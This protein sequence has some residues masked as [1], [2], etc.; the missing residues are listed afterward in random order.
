MISNRLGYALLA[1]LLVEC[2]FGEQRNRF[3]GGVSSGAIVVLLLFLKLN[4]FGAAG[5]CF[6]L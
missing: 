6:C 4:F 2:A 5:F 3:W 1:V